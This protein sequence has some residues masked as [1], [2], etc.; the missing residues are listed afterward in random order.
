MEHLEPILPVY[1]LETAEQALALLNPKRADMLRLL[2]EPASASELARRIGEP[3]QK[4]NYHLKSLEKVGLVR[5]SGTRQVKNLVEVLY[6]AVARTYV[7]P[8]AFGWPEEL[9]SRLKTQG[10]LRHLVSAAEQIRNDAVRLMDAADET[11][12][13]PSAAME[14]EVDL[15]DEAAREA[16]IRAYTEAVK[17]VAGKFRAPQGSKEHAFRV[18]AVIYPQIEAGGTEHER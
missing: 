7:I 10:A 8:D 5:R 1:R 9:R 2:D 4:V 6:R 18:M 16:F 15:P 12:E 13:V 17:Q 14:F 11:A 3:A